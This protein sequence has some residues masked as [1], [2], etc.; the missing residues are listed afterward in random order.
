MDKLLK[1]VLNN[2]CFLF[3]Y[4]EQVTCTNNFNLFKGKTCSQGKFLTKVE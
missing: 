3:I 2:E 4:V 1:L